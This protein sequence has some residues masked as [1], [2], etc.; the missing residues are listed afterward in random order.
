LFATFGTLFVVPIMY[1]LLRKDVPVDVGEEVD[2]AQQEIDE[3]E[4]KA[5]EERKQKSGP[6]SEQPSEGTA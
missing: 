6:R 4:Q 2:K 5:A 1:S 3:R